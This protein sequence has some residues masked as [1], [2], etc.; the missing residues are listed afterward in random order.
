[1]KKYILIL[2]ISKSQTNETH[3]FKPKKNYDILKDP[4]IRL[5]GREIKEHQRRNPNG[6]ERTP[7]EEKKGEE[8]SADD[9]PKKIDQ[10][11]RREKIR[12]DQS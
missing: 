7:Q 10:D 6:G 11:H 9:G 3:Q 8:G 1:M 4:V 12:R 2:R 5:K